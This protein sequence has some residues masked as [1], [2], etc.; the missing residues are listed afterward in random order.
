MPP[1]LIFRMKGKEKKLRAP[2]TEPS[3][4]DSIYQ[5]ISNS[6]AI[7]LGSYM[8]QIG[9]AFDHR[10]RKSERLDTVSTKGRSKGIKKKKQGKNN[11]NRLPT[12][13]IES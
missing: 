8:Q 1:H 12:Y 3:N 7:Y 13:L 11:N 4:Y 2:N 10:K 6:K 9:I 5:S